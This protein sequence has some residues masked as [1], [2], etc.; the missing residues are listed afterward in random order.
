MYIVCNICCAIGLSHYADVFKAIDEILT[1]VVDF[2]GKLNFEPTE[3]K[4]VNNLGFE[5]SG[6]SYLDGE[7]SMFNIGQAGIH[8]GGFNTNCIQRKIAFNAKINDLRQNIME[9]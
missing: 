3:T 8:R 7:W 4:R 5:V 2:F 6:R 1:Q 9:L